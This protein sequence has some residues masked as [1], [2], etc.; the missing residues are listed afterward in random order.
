MAYRGQ[1]ANRDSL[2]W[3]VVDAALYNE[4]FAGQGPSMPRC[5][6]CLADTHASLE[7]FHAPLEGSNTVE[8]S[9]AHKLAKSL[10][11]ITASSE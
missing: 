6:F 9:V 10:I 4:A 8:G 3:A 5:K 11:S 1:A 2:D 7:C